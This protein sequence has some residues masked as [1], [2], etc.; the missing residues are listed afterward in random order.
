MCWYCELKEGD[1]YPDGK[2]VTLAIDHKSPPSKYI[3]KYHPNHPTN[4][5]TACVKCNCSKGELNLPEYLE[6]EGLMHRYSL[7]RNHLRVKWEPFLDRVIMEERVAA[8]IE[9]EIDRRVAS[10]FLIRV[11]V[12]SFDDSYTYADTVPPQGDEDI[13][14]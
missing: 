8:G 11:V 2:P 13:P 12:D 10:G 9:A 14:F 1:T 7:I 5:I 3:G 4:L 6:R